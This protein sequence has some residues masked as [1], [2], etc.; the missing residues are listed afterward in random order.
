[1][2]SIIV[3][4]KE[5]IRKGLINLLSMIDADVEVIGEC[6]SVQEAVIVTKACNPE[7]GIMQDIC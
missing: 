1:M 6:E 5:Y 4:D 2:K 7:H 3:E